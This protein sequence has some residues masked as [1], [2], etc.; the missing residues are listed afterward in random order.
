M[1][2]KLDPRDIKEI[3]FR[4]ALRLGMLRHTSPTTSGKKPFLM[5]FR[6]TSNP[7]IFRAG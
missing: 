2:S 7:N 4:G 3:G 1:L 5:T 6:E